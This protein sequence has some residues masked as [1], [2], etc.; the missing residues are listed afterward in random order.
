MGTKEQRPQQAPDEAAK[1]R[2]EPEAEVVEG[3]LREALNNGD[4]GVDYQRSDYSQDAEQD[5][6]IHAESNHSTHR[7]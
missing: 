7:R 4:Y 3:S 6:A 5:P 2:T 1:A